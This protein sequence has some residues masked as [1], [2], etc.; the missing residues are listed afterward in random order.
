MCA[1]TGGFPDDVSSGLRVLAVYIYI[2]S[3]GAWGLVALRPCHWP[4]RRGGEPVGVLVIHDWD[5][6]W[7]GRCSSGR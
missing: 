2:L 4:S 1:R 7:F 3:G 6:S 5:A